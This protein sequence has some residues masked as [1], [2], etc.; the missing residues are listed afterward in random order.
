MS[1]VLIFMRA[2]NMLI[3]YFIFKNFY[4]LLGKIGPEL[5][6]VPFFFYFLSGMLPQNDLSG[7]YVHSQYSNP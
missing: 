3:S 5:T 7:V 6:S 2:F 1:G 4:F